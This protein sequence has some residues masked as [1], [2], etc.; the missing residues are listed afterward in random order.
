VNVHVDGADHTNYED[1]V[2]QEHG[3]DSR[4]GVFLLQAGEEQHVQVDER[5]S[6]LKVIYQS[7]ITM[8]HYLK[9]AT[10]Q[11]TLSSHSS[12]SLPSTYLMNMA[13]MKMIPQ[14]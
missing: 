4:K 7:Q 1:D 8:T 10:H 11:L 12:I 5:A 2:V 13:K 14:Q 9:T 3:E 6:S